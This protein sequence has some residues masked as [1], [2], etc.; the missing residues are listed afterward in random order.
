[1]RNSAFRTLFTN[2]LNNKRYDIEKHIEMALLDDS[3]R[4]NAVFIAAEYFKDL[5][6][7]SKIVKT[8]EYYHQS[9]FKRLS[10]NKHSSMIEIRRMAVSNKEI[11]KI[12]QHLTTNTDPVTLFE[13]AKAL[14]RNRQELAAPMIE[15]AISVPRVYLKSASRESF[16][17]MKSLSKLSIDFSTKVAV[18]NRE[19]EDLFQSPSKTISMLANLTLLKTGTS[20]T[21]KYLVCEIEPFRQTMSESYKVMAIETME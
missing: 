14:T 7:R 10:I 11:S 1:M 21:V 5:N 15:K 2:L 12:S 8:I 6:I 19:I 3:S 4:D 18:A 16:V 20:E 13:A 17:G 9:F